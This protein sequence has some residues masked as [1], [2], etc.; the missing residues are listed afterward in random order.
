MRL[1][2]YLSISMAISFALV[3]IIFLLIPNEVLTFFNNISLQIGM[4]ET[5]LTVTSFFIILAVAYMYLVSLIAF[6][7]FHNPRNIYFPFLLANAKLASSLLSL[8]IFLIS[9]P[10]L[11]FISNSIIDGL[12][13]LTCL[14]LYFNLK[15]K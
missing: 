5:P 14:L 3:G 15:K 2:R 6:M 11:I 7:M 4:K 10:Y 1:Y 12:L 13:G 8:G 9:Q